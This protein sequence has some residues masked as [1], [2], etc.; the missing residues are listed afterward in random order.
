MNKKILLISSNSSSRGGGERYLIYLTQGLHQL[1]YEVHVLLSSKNYM[2][3]WAN[4][5]DNEGAKVHRLQL[6]GLRHRPL[7]FIQSLTDRRQQQ[8]IADFCRQMNPKVILVNQQYDED[9]L[10]YVLGAIKAKT[11]P[12]CGIIHMPMTASKNKRPLGKL[13]GKLLHK[14]YL[15][16]T[17]QKIFVSQGCQQEFNNYYQIFDST[18]VVNLGCPFNTIS[19]SATNLLENCLDKLPVI[20]FIGQFVPQKNLSLLTDSWLWLNSQGIKTKLLLVGD[21]VE[22]SAIEQK[23]ITFA[24]PETWEIT[25]WQTNPEKYLSGM[26]IYAMTSHFEGLPLSL[27][28][29]SGNGVPAVVTNFHGASD[30]ARQAPWVKVVESNNSVSF[31]KNLLNTLN[32]ISCCQQAA[33]KGQARFREYFSTKRMA[34]DTLNAIEIT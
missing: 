19:S 23:L 33:R 3:E 2:D 10:D 32:N 25:G 13:R 11:A 29:A 1:G 26:D 24:P 28:E 7:R 30:I 20:G 15:D 8:K 6:I 4:C 31:G 12:V 21:G 14:W 9:G 5:L 34:R 16:N 22:K 17:Y 18:S 27:I